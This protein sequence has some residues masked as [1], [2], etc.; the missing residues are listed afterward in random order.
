M[1]RVNYSRDDLREIFAPQRGLDVPERGAS[2]RPLDV[3]HSGF[4]LTAVSRTSRFAG[5]SSL[6][7][8]RAGCFPWTFLAL[9]FFAPFC[10]RWAFFAFGPS[11]LELAEQRWGKGSGVLEES[12]KM[13]EAKLSKDFLCKSKAS[14]RDRSFLD[15]PGAI[16]SS[17]E[18]RLRV[19]WLLKNK[20][21]ITLEASVKIE[22]QQGQCSCSCINMGS[23]SKR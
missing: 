2:R 15:S 10:F 22:I 4:A 12:H 1:S 19:D 16:V 21:G 7:T 20:S 18:A 3:L 5:T 14:T 9:G 13:F 11:F 23:R 17:K 8:P 6:F